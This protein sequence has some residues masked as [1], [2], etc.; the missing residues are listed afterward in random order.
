[1]NWLLRCVTQPIC[2][3]DLL[4]Y[5]VSSLTPSSGEDED[6]EE[7]E[8]DKDKKKEDK[9]KKDQEASRKR[10]TDDKTEGIENVHRKYKFKIYNVKTIFTSFDQNTAEFYD[11]N[12]LLS[13]ICQNL[14]WNHAMLH[15][16]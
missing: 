11:N 2:L 10:R 6:Q 1:M 12:I 16:M 14:G 15:Y 9:V 4:W 13:M 8:E 3:H 7:E 5:F